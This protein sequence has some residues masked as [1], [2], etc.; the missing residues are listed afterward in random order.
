MGRNGRLKPT[1]FQGHVDV[2]L[3]PS[4]S[5]NYFTVCDSNKRT[6]L[7]IEEVFHFLL[8]VCDLSIP[9]LCGESKQLLVSKAVTGQSWDFSPTLGIPLSWALCIQ[10][11]TTVPR[12]LAGV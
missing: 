6:T 7:F 4:L 5:G 2:K 10:M 12:D 9:G 11:L 3:T 8:Q 1:H